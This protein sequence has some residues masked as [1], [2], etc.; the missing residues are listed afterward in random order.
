M[1]RKRIG[2][3]DAIMIRLDGNKALYPLVYSQYSSD[4]IRANLRTRGIQ[5]LS[6][7]SEFCRQLE[8]ELVAAAAS[9]AIPADSSEDE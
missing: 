4:A 1:S 5:T 3:L 7:A 6:A 8:E 2:Y 9:A